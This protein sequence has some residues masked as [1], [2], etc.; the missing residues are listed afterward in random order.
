MV[1]WNREQYIRECLSSLIRQDTRDIP[2]FVIYVTSDGSTDSTEEIVKEFGVFNVVNLG[3]NGKACVGLSKNRCVSKA[4][5]GGCDVIQM[6]DS[7]DRAKPDLLRKMYT[8]LT[9][10]DLDWVNCAGRAFGGADYRLTSHP[11][12]TYDQE[13]VTNVLTSWGM[14]KAETLR[15]ENYDPTFFSCEDWEIYIRLLKKGYK[16]GVLDEELVEYRVH[17]DQLSYAKQVG[18][19]D[20]TQNIWKDK[21]KQMYP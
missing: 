19:V 11:D 20:V 21:L 3:N 12:A 4:L 6:L 16:Y 14:F 2:P 10:H 18:K 17:D 9:T 1:A 13:K 7:D 8:I 15:K 5:S